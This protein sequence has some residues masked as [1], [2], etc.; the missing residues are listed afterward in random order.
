MWGVSLVLEN[1]SCVVVSCSCLS[2]VCS[3]VSSVCNCLSS[4]SSA[5]S[6]VFTGGLAVVCICCA[7]CL[8]VRVCWSLVSSVFKCSSCSGVSCW[9]SISA[10]R[11]A[12]MVSVF[13]RRIAVMNK[14]LL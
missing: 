6:C 3:L 9:S 7:L 10:C 13:S 14:A 5:H 11:L 8:C 4:V 12:M 2:F 1:F